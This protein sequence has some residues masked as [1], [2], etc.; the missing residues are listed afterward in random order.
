MDTGLYNSQSQN[1]TAPSGSSGAEDHPCAA[2]I[3]TFTTCMNENRGNM[4]IC[5]WYMDQL[6]ACKQAARLY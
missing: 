1:Q 3:K 6:K 4:D 2:D 5:G